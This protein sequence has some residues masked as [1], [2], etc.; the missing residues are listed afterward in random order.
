[1]AKIKRSSKYDFFKNDKDPDKNEKKSAKKI[2]KNIFR[3]FKIVIYIC[4]GGISLTGCI[5]SFVV[6]TSSTVGSGL[7]IYRSE[8]EISPFVNTYFIQEELDKDGNI[9]SQKLL[10]NTKDNF[11]L[12]DQKEIEAI[13]KQLTLNNVK[14]YG[15]YGNHSS[16]LRIVNNKGKTISNT[17]DIT[18]VSPEEDLLTRGASWSN[19]S[20]SNNN[21]IILNSI[22]L[23]AL[24]EDPFSEYQLANEIIEIPIFVQKRP[25]E[26]PTDK[27]ELA[28]YNNPVVAI[29]NKSWKPFLPNPA[30][31]AEYKLVVISDKENSKGK[32]IDPWNDKPID[33]NTQEGKDRIKQFKYNFEFEKVMLKINVADSAA[34]KFARDYLQS[35]ANVM[36][37]FKQFEHF[38]A[39]LP[40]TSPVDPSQTII[41]VKRFQNLTNLKDIQTPPN[42]TTIVNEQNLYNTELKTAIETYL[43]QILGII[44]NTGFN[45]KQLNF[46]GDEPD[47]WT[48]PRTLAFLPKESFNPSNYLI[49]ASPE[50]QKPI[51]SFSDAWS[52]GP[53][54]GLVVYPIGKLVQDLAYSM[55][56][57]NGFESV[58]S[59]AISVIIARLFTLIVTYKSAFAQSKQAALAP[60]KAKIDAKYAAYKGNK[61]MEQ[62]KRQETA[63]LYKKNGISMVTPLLSVLVSAPIFLAMWRIVQGIPL[64]KATEWLGINFSSLSYQELFGGAWQYLPLILLAAIIQAGS[65]LVPRLLNKKRVSE[66]AN[67]AEKEALKKANKTQNIVMVVFVFMALIFE[68]GIQ[69]YWIVGGIWMMLQSMLIHH[70]QKTNFFKEKLI[71]Y[72]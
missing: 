18:S 58:L 51:L 28:S 48:T 57:L 52:L 56:N 13:H 4:L 12:K 45:F 19:N 3:W 36:I 42:N 31:P 32:Y 30:N 67:V 54:Y 7:E 21:I 6:R 27:T 37:Q 8:N 49:N 69:I 63:E 34:S 41:P 25:I 33:Q 40:N 14:Y 24:N 66:R 55:P 16:S 9:K 72:V 61:T 39:Q 1:M 71:K 10:I 60:K 11:L 62:R 15:Q 46:S 59:I 26:K 43:T 64:L 22:Y 38:D 70:I 20:N 35:L 50:P 5:Q 68:A 23:N 53:F 29:G 44:A 2:F 65:Q 17:L 47:A